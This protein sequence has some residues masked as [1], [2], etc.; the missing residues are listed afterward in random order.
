MSTNPDSTARRNFNAFL[1]HAVFLALTTTFTD[2][3][4]ILPSLV[5]TS[6][7]SDLQL[8]ILTAI[9]VGTPILG[10]LFFASYLHL[11]SRKKP[12]LLF[13]INL[14]VFILSITALVLW[15]AEALAG[16]GL[17][18][19]IFL[20]MFVF[21]LAGTFAGVSYTDILGKS[22]PETMR[23]SFFVRR[24]IFTSIAILISAL[25]ARSILA[26][27]HYPANYVLLF[28]LAAALLL[29]A[30]A[31]FWRIKEKP[32]AI[33][34]GTHNF[35]M[36]IK[37]IPAT[38]KK[39]PNLRSYI[40]FSNFAGFSLTLMPFFIALAKT[41]YELT[42]EQIGMFLLLQIIGMIVSNFIWAQI[43]KKHHF[44]GIIKGCV[45]I[46]SLLPVLALI[47]VHLPIYF[48]WL[49]FFLM[50]FTMSAR[51]IGYEGL[52]IEITDDENRALHKGIVGA[53]RLSTAFFPLIAG[54]L[55]GYVGYETIFILSSIMIAT[56][57]YFIREL[58]VPS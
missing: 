58:H 40:L 37:S 42:G 30:S 55:I 53:T 10:E 47:F 34:A 39:N 44:I 32:V 16:Q 31:G 5:V 26:E 35:L 57:L 43:I 2:V 45:A 24:Q 54:W 51:R 8:G 50:G 1:W 49:I 56:S 28:I 3:N 13:G 21:A 36:V 20:L 25:I 41:S 48:Y 46:G 22:L 15:R 12:F 14:R 18:S 7:G 9:M 6:G 29:V 11:K 27:M 17:I 19:L 4:T 38:F 33:T 52:F 23:Q